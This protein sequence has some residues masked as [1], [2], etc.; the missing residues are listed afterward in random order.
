MFGELPR[1]ES[2]TYTF[3]SDYLPWAERR[4][5]GASQQHRAVTP[6]ALR[7]PG[8]RQGILGTVAHE[9]FHAWNMERIRSRAIEP[10]NF[11]DANMSGEL[12]LGEGFTSYYDDLIMQRAGLQSLDDLLAELRRR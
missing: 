8:Q 11:E 2:N 5:H 3:L 7:N 9:F 10:F 6:G 1:F 12:W 4:R